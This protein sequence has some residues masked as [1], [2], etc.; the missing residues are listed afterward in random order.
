[1]NTAPTRQKA[2]NRS[3]RLASDPVT[4]RILLIAGDALIEI[5]DVLMPAF[6]QELEALRVDLQRKERD[7]SC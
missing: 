1:M 3:S 6:K 4:L 2:S 7:A 5:C